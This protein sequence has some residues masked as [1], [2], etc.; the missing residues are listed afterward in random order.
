[1]DW[2]GVFVGLGA[3]AAFGVT[4]SGWRRSI[5]ARSALLIYSLLVAMCV[6]ILEDYRGPMRIVEVLSGALLVAG[7]ATLGVWVNARQ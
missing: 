6:V 7:F 3:V 1:L 5:W 4:V 2:N